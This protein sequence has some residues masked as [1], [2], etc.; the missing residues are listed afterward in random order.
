MLQAR[1][2]VR[3][4]H[5]ERRKTFK[6]FSMGEMGNY[7]ADAI[8]GGHVDKL[9]GV[10]KHLRIVEIIEVILVKSYENHINIRP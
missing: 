2:Q 7:I 4:A 6:E 1:E 5:A 8:V 3:L 9:T 10:I